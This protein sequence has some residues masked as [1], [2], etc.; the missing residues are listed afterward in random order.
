VTVTF[1]SASSYVATPRVIL[2]ALNSATAASQPYIAAVS[3]TAFTIG[4][5]VAPAASQ[6]AGTYQLAFQIVG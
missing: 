3:A 2:T 5:A 6:G 1:A 4:F